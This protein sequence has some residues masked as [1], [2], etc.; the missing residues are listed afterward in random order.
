MVR[1]KHASR[2]GRTED[3]EEMLKTGSGSVGSYGFAA[4]VWMRG[5]TVFAEARVF[6]REP[7]TRTLGMLGAIRVEAHEGEQAIKLLQAKLEEKFGSLRWCR[8]Y[9]GEK[10]EV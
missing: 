6:V 2:L 10:S 5:G 1:E 8:W 4:A 3:A 7:T 9:S